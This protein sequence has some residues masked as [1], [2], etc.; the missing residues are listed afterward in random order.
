M[1]F[2]NPT[3]DIA[4]KKLFG[5]EQH[6]NVLISFLNAVLELRDAQA[7]TEITILNPYQAPKIDLLK[8]TNLDVRATTAA[9]VTFI[10]EMQVEREP[11]FAKRALYYAA[12]AYVGQLKRGELYP[13]LNQVIFIGI[14]DFTLFQSPHYLSKHLIL[15]HQTLR[16]EITD[17]ELNFIE[18]PKFEKQAG[19]LATIT[20]KWIY[21]FKH[22]RDFT[23]IPEA[24]A[25]SPEFVEAFTLL[26]EHAWNQDELDAYE[27]WELKD[28]GHIVAMEAAVREA[29]G[30]ATRKGREEGMKEGMKEGIKE[31]EH[32]QARHT[33]AEM[34]RDGV[35]LEQIMKWTGL[36]RDVIEALR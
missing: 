32:Q 6:P 31:G 21:F 12:K 29:V 34:L 8:E 10:V 11:F 1:K 19:E 7:I 36:P 23:L 16:R 14:L 3:S 4:F 13:K 25:A 15:D 33:A 35:P 18:L 20:D 22:A 9:G 26:S 30:E 17:L 24:F 5:S 2:A 27:Y 28:A